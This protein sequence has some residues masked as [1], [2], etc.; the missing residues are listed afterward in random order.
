MTNPLLVHIGLFGVFSILLGF[1]LAYLECSL[2]IRVHIGLFGVFSI[3][4]GFTLA[5]LECS[6]FIRV[7]IGL[8]ECPLFY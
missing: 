2:F 1:T 4:L 8:L 5:Y 3:L 7:H 6:L